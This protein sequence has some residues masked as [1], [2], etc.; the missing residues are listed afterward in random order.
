MGEAVRC[1]KGLECTVHCVAR[2]MTWDEIEDSDAVPVSSQH[3]NE[4]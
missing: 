2:C 1:K 3:G 4:S